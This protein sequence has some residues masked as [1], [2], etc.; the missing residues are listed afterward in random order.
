MFAFRIA[1]QFTN[2]VG[3]FLAYS[4]PARGVQC[5]RE[6]HD[7]DE[8]TRLLRGVR[9]SVLSELNLGFRF[10]KLQ[11]D[12]LVDLFGFFARFL[13]SGSI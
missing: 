12:V 1:A 3:K 4:F 6:K 5:A 9:R 11:F 8:I 13:R 7:D 10:A 2:S